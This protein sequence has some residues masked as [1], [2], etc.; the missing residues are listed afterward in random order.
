MNKKKILI[1]TLIVIILV[2]V[3]I[4]V[5]KS[6]SNKNKEKE[7]INNTNTQNLEVPNVEIDKNQIDYQE[8]TTVNE[9][10]DFT[11][12]SGDSDLYEITT[13]Y[14]G[15]KVLKIKDN[16][17]YDVTMAGILKQAKPE[18]SEIDNLKQKA[19]NK[20]G[21]WISQ[22][23][24]TEFLNL[25]KEIT[26]SKYTINEEGYLEIE[27]K[28]SQN[29]T[30]KR[31]EKIILADK[32]FAIDIS[33]TDYT[34]DSVTGQIVENPF[35]QLDSYQAFDYVANDGSYIIVITTNKQ[36]SLS[37]SEIIKYV[38]QQMENV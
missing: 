31:L 21:I 19:P 5:I 25:L 9:L 33:G 15:R 35:E 11:G 7:N 37:N 20:T 12:A 6:I 13:E 2:I 38:I 18:Y 3:G 1:I 27:D 17:Q 29:E 23:S 30:D 22:N 34:I 24:K 4:I 10:K 16:K 14:D 36:K 32:L 26:N 8:N 28:S